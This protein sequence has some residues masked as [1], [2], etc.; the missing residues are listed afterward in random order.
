VL[1]SAEKIISKKPQ[2]NSSPFGSTENAI[3]ED[4]GQKTLVYL[5]QPISDGS[6][7]QM[8]WKNM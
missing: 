7:H 3:W 8:F 4:R 2:S 5:S 1:N 6:Q